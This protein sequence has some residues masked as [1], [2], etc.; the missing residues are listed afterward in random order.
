V[1]WSD[2]HTKS[3]KLA[4]EAEAALKDGELVEARRLY[5]D[6]AKAEVEALKR[7]DKTKQRTL[8]IITVS[9]VAL[10]YKAKQFAQ[11]E[12]IAYQVL[13]EGSLPEFAVIQV[14]ELL[15]T[16][17]NEVERQ[18]ADVKFIPDQVIVSIKGGEIVRGGAPL[19]LIVEKV[20]VVQSL[21]YRTTE[22]LMGLP[23]RV[24]GGPSQEIRQSCR[25]WLFQAAPGSYQF[26]V[27]MQESPQ[28]ELF[29]SAK[30][31]SHEVASKFLQ[32]LRTSTEDPDISL[33]EIVPNVDYRKT[34]LNLTRNLAPTG[35]TFQSMEI[36]APGD[37]PV[38]LMPS[39]RKIISETIRRQRVKEKESTELHEQTLAGIL[40]AVHLDKDWLEV[41][42]EN[43]NIHVEGVG[44]TVDDVIGPMVNR[45][46]IVQTVKDSKSRYFFRDI[47]PAE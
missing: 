1:T 16:I 14:K 42:V 32:I 37:N 20:Q 9:A 15:Q 35:K 26:A 6:A 2:F 30:P 5:A 24:H 11:A 41:T 12:Q 10:W 33:S 44:D 38:I 19:D 47:E 36:Q 39:E 17:W 28:L 27:A 3:E 21:F 29:P 23:H 18:R 8:G 31:K 22:F 43:E 4:S 40:R 25:P 34:F 46:V 13:S 7:L 45:P